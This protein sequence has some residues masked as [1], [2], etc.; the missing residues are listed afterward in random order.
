MQ[1]ASRYLSKQLEVYVLPKYKMEACGRGLQGTEDKVVP[2]NQAEDMYAAIK[3][4][5]ISTALVLF[6]GE[7]HGFRG[8][9]PIRRALEGELFFYGKVL[10]FHAELSEDLEGFDIVNLK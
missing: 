8:A 7:Q 4:K 5:G 3:K 10:G 1:H 6:E 2:P 9:I